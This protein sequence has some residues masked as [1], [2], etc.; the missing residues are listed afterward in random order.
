MLMSQTLNLP[1]IRHGFLTRE[2]GVSTA[3]Y[4]SLNCGPG[5]LD[6]S[7]A[8]VQN[9]KRALELLGL[10]GTQLLSCYQIHSPTVVQV[11]EPWEA[12]NAPQ[13]DAMVTN[14]SGL[15]LG[16]LTADCAPVLFCDGA[17]GVIGAAHAGWKGAVG[18]VLQ[19]TVSQMVKLG[20]QQNR[21]HAVAG[22]CIHQHSCEVGAE[23]R[24]QVI[25]QSAWADWCF[26]RSPRAGHYQ[27]DLP[28]YVS[29]ELQRLNLGAVELIDHDTYGDEQR[30]YSYRRT[31]HRGEA[32]YGRQISV[33]GL[34]D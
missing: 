30:F 10:N 34:A 29:G 1:G 12:Q 16:I 33:I 24:L 22:P 17:A 2:G 9:R 31:T 19:A 5:S 32:D 11:N 4:A 8:V 28:S 25:S 20:A 14:K 3:I 23:L 18:G 6:D 27:F 13:A 15:A 21:V 7:H 26:E